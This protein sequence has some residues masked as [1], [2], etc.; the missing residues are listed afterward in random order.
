MT[1]MEQ[2]PHIQNVVVTMAQAHGMLNRY[3]PVKDILE[4]AAT[5]FQ[6]DGVDTADVEALEA[7]LHT[8]TYD[9]V[10]TLADGEEEEM[11][12]LMADSPVGSEGMCV[13]QLF[14]DVWTALCEWEAPRRYVNPRPTV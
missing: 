4:T 6:A 12:A 1:F 10:E 11:S 7:W 3:E 13:A 2:H 9:Q 14:D 8:L 5:C